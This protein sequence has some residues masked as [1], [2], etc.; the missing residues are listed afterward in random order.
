MAKTTLQTIT[1]PADPDEDD[2]LSAAA[3][4][5]VA[6]HPEAE[7]WDLRPR[8]EDEDE[9]ET[10]L[11]TVPIADVERGDA[12]NPYTIHGYPVVKHD[13]CL[14]EAGN[15]PANLVLVDRGE[16]AMHRWVTAIHPLC[17]SEWVWGHYFS[18]RSDAERD[19][20]KRAVAYC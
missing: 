1:V 14:P 9:R 7:G 6:E 20:E 12:E 15:M 17:H 5:Y 13:R 11:L 8:W 4:A 10:V 2:C 19:Y 16:G 18:E 3:D